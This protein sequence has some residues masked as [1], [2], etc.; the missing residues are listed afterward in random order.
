MGLN[1]NEVSNKWDLITKYRN[2]I[3]GLIVYDPAQIH[4]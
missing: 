3:S 2:E 1:W 4:T